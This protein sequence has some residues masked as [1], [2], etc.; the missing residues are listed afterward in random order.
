[1]ATAQRDAQGEMDMGGHGLV[2]GW[3]RVRLRGGRTRAGHGLA[4]GGVAWRAPTSC[5]RTWKAPAYCERAWKKP[6][7]CAY[8]TA[9][10][11]ARTA[12]HP[13]RAA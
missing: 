3:Q 7:F 2:T 5:V 6:A 11:T 1:M 12:R 8:R 13:S 10:L 9:A 4:T